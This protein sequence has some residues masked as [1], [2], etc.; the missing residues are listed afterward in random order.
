MKSWC[1][2]PD[3]QSLVINKSKK[4]QKEL[5]SIILSAPSRRLKWWSGKHSSHCMVF[6]FS[7]ELCSFCFVTLWLQC[8]SQSYP[9]L[10]LVICS[11]DVELKK[12]EFLNWAFPQHSPTHTHAIFYRHISF[13][14][15]QHN[16]HTHI[17]DVLADYILRVVVYPSCLTWFQSGGGSKLSFSCALHVSKVKAWKLRKRMLHILNYTGIWWSRVVMHILGLYVDPG[18]FTLVYFHNHHLLPKIYTERH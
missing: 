16:S 5:I 13:L 8:K 18:N 17:F 3:G 2:A 9:F 6:L 15:Y 11:L 14:R 4:W 1:C 12:K 10:L 7:W